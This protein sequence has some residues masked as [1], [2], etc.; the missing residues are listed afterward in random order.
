MEYACER[1]IEPGVPER[2][3]AQEEDE[4]EVEQTIGD[5]WQDGPLRDD[6]LGPAD[7]A[8][9]MSFVLRPFR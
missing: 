1:L 8:V 7:N 5:A 2:E 3:G 6:A 4:L 9:I